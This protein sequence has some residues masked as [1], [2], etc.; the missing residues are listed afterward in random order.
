MSQPSRSAL[1]VAHE[2]TIAGQPAGVIHRDVKPANI[3]VSSSGDIR[4]TDFGIARPVTRQ[5][6]RE[7][8]PG[9]L[10][11]MPPEQAR[12][13]AERSSDLFGDPAFD[14]GP[15]DELAN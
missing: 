7:M 2:H 12:G 4:L 1:Y 9:T 13:Q 6:S 8:P 5:S 3:L 14:Q 11:Y 10:R 15:L